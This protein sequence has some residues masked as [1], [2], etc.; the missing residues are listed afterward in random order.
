MQ[1]RELKAAGLHHLQDPKQLLFMQKQGAIVNGVL[2]GDID[3]GFIRTDQLERTVDSSTGELVDPSK[4]KIINPQQGLVSDGAP[5]PFTASTRLY[6]NWNMV[7]FPH[8]PE[9][10]A[11][12]VQ[13]SLLQQNE[14]AAFAP[15]LLECLAGEGCDTAFDGCHSRCY[16]SLDATKTR[17]CLTTVETILAANQAAV[18]GKNAGWKTSSSYMGIRNMQEEVG[19]IRFDEV[20]KSARCNRGS[21]LSDAVV[22]PEGHFKR[23]SAD[24]DNG[25]AD[26]G[27]DCLGYTCLCKPCVLSYDVDFIPW[28]SERGQDKSLVPQD[29][30]QDHGCA[31]FAYCGAV[32]QG[33]SITFQATDNKRRRNIMFEAKVL[34]G[35]EQEVYPMWPVG[36]FVYQFEFDATHRHNGALIIEVFA[37]E[38]PI[39]ESPFRF[40][41]IPRD[42][43]LDTGDDLREPNTHGQC[44]CESGSV[45]MFGKC[46]TLAMLLPCIIVPC[47]LLFAVLALMYA[48][49]RRKK[50]DLVWKIAPGDL[51]FPTPAVTLGEGS[52]GVV[53]LSN[54]RGTVCAVK[55]PYQPGSGKT[56][57]SHEKSVG[58]THLP[59]SL[60]RERSDHSD[61][62]EGSTADGW[63]VA[64]SGSGGSTPIRR[65][66]A[67]W[68]GSGSHFKE[69]FTKE[70]RH[71]SQL[72]HPN[73]ATVLGAVVSES[74]DPM[75]VLE[76]MEL[77]SLY[78]V[79]HNNNM[80]LEKD[81]VFPIVRDIIS[82]IR[83]LHTANPAVIHGDL[84]SRNILVDGNF[85]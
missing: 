20:T 24:I 61:E 43:A 48:N 38:H 79:L 19:F 34:V 67:L 57:L 23:S 51:S 69:E 27:M 2:K 84:K 17:D 45:E 9:G 15:Q 77:G 47:V 63:L 59:S 32:E 85:R 6:P 81:L 3:V 31:K 39:P 14:R 22:C 78:D 4:V 46:V 13:T 55:R 18:T 52:F 10:V 16:A 29:V 44:V 25:C 37:G 35:D 49:Y 65:L 30:P 80:I 58:S 56:T 42:C 62:E 12:K 68:S 53:L 41:V 71:L 5:F 54:Y 82:G 1:F 75:L 8:V 21:E 40:E 7:S 33:G 66:V 26:L 36:D 64:L 28:K 74:Q 72:R 76:H 70:M 73:I 83:F 50:A 60:S 11:Q